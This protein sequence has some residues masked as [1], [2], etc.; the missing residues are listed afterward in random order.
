MTHEQKNGEA[1]QDFVRTHGALIAIKTNCA[2]SELGT[3]WTETCQNNCIA[4]ETTKPRNPQQNPTNKRIGDIGSMVKRCMR[5]FNIPIKKHD[6]VQ[7]WFTDAHNHLSSCNP[8]WR[9]PLEFSTGHT[10]DIL[11]FWFYV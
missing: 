5:A 2:Q 8:H 3:K 4:Q 6:W 1:L 9:T 7:K 10:P 11:A